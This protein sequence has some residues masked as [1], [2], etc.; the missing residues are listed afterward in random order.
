MGSWRV[1]ERVMSEGTVAEKVRRF[2]QEIKRGR[3]IRL[4][5]R[6]KEGRKGDEG[7]DTVNKG[8]GEE[9]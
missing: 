5:G 9:S 7:K 1:D 6:G 8:N 2:E 4:S 3:N